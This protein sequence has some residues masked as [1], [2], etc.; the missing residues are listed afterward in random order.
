MKKNKGFTLIELLGTIIVLGILIGIAIPVI[1][2][3]IKQGKTKYYNSLEKTIEA[4][5]R[6]YLEDYRALLPRGEVGNVTIISGDE[7]L[8]NNYIDKIVDTDGNPCMA[9]VAAKKIGTNEFE[10]HTCLKCKQI[11]GTRK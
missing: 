7:L 2:N 1:S 11:E 5:A 8:I 3:Y 6:D 9:E 4:S 10:Y